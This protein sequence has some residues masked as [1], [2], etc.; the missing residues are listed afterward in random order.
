ML[1]YSKL[2]FFLIKRYLFGTIYKELCLYWNTSNSPYLS[3]INVQ[4]C[5]IRTYMSVLHVH[6]N[7]IDSMQWKLQYFI[8]GFEVQSRQNDEKCEFFSFHSCSVIVLYILKTQL[9]IV[10]FIVLFFQGNMKC[11]IWL[12]TNFLSEHYN[13]EKLT[14][15]FSKFCQH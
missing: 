5:M 15:E 10:T 9:V 11:K 4:F 3:L 6:I 14:D 2:L 13:V 1:R 12:F 7:E 8:N